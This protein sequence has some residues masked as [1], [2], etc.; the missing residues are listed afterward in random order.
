MN[1]L[2]TAI[3]GLDEQGQL[4]LEAAAKLDYFQ[5]QA[6]ADR[7]AE[8]AKKTA[9]KYGCLPYDDYRQLIMQNQ[10][11]CLLVAAGLY[12]CDE[13]VRTAMKKKCNIFKLSPPAKNFTQAGELVRLAEEENIKFAVA[14]PSRFAQGFLALKKFLQE[15]RIEQIFLLTAVYNGANEHT[16][17]WQADPKLAGGGVLLYNCYEIIDQIVWNFGVPQQ[18]YSLNTNQATDKQQ[19]LYLTEDTA[20]VTMKF[21]DTFFGTLTAGRN[22]GPKQ[23]FLKIYGKDKALTVTGNLFIISDHLGRTIEEFEYRDDRICCMNRVLENFALSILSPDKNRLCSSAEENLKDMAVIE[24]A[25]L[26]ARTGMP[27]EPPR[28]L[29]MPSSSAVTA[30]I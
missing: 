7:D 21:T 23:D 14:N 29:Q 5:V 22:L 19:R 9:G 25:Y 24:S 13:Y 17:L 1:Q 16:P 3:L 12:S 10:F 18:V 20:V 15:N 11:D 30:A 27:E 8:L 4:L 28:I 6:V 26:S 2:K